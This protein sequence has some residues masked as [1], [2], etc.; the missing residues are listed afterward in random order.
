MENDLLLVLATCPSK[1]EAKLVAN[2]LL[3]ESVAACVNILPNI[4][5][6]YSWNDNIEQT[7]ECL[8]LIKTRSDYFDQVKLIVERYIS[9]GI[10][11]CIAIKINDG[12][13]KYLNWLKNTLK[14]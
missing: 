11:E 6:H 12:S 2:K 8:L 14:G 13:T 3:T 4:Q 7:A 1:E 9:Y 10:P 5:S